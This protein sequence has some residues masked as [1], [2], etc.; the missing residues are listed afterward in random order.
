MEKYAKVCD[1]VV[2][3]EL[4]EFYVQIEGK[5]VAKGRIEVETEKIHYKTE[6]HDS[7]F[8]NYITH[9]CRRASE[10]LRSARRESLL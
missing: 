2:D 4:G 9:M 8:Y 7:D 3:F 6:I 5:N 10:Q 1:F